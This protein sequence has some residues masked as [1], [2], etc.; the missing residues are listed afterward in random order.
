MEVLREVLKLKT[1]SF[2]KESKELDK[3]NSLLVLDRMKIIAQATILMS[4]FWTYMDWMIVKNG[5]NKAYCYTLIAL[6]ITCVVASAIL[7]IISKRI[8]AI[9]DNEKH[10]MLNITVK[11]YVF[12]YIFVGVIS[13]LNSQRYTGNIYT[14]IILS[15]IAA[16]AFALKPSYM[17]FAYGTNHFIF[18]IG[19]GIL[20][21]DMDSFFE[22]SINTTVMAG[23]AFL[24]SLAFYSHRER[25]F[26]Y[27][28]E[29]KE[30][31][32][33]FKKL[34]Y[35]NPYPVFITSLA[36]GR[37]IEANKRAYSLFEIDE[38]SLDSFEGID[39]FIN[40]DSRQALQ[41][42]LIEHNSI[43]NRIVEYDF[44]GKKLWATANYELIEYHGEKCILTGIMDITE[45]R[46][47][48]EELAYY[49]S[50][51]ALTGIYNR[52]IGIKK[53]EEL[54]A[55]AKK[56][57]LEFVLCFIDINKLK[58]INDTYGHSEGDRYILSFCEI[59]KN[60]LHEE[61]IFF[62]LGGDEFIIIFK[63][64]K[65]QQ[66]EEFW[67]WLL[68]QLEKKYIQ[69]ELPYR[70]LV[71]HGLFY[72]CSGMDMDA[73]CIIEEADKNMYLEKKKLNEDSHIDMV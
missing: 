58:H 50:I 66:V 42:D 31:E 67:M 28:K 13:S 54:L 1:V 3:Y 33:N 16:V 18:L 46:K 32:E 64:R 65:L 55:E 59:V 71:S 26:S 2:D 25:E 57:F 14:Y 73:Y 48:G 68:E 11:I 38:S 70:V 17:F 15:L 10:N 24:I 40:N 45:I 60:E 30:S 51:D 61:D 8:K 39:C 47:E 62:R 36:D 43:F 5:A 53:L 49:A 12:I 56:E 6:H 37:I 20:A 44:K 35:A 29:L 23:A 7:I 27:R 41:Q 4:I 34:F 69:E 19:L 72:Y 22:K 52:R 63:N 9:V 21:K